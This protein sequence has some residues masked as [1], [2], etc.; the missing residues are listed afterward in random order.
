VGKDYPCFDSHSVLEAIA[1][2]VPKDSRCEV[3][4]DALTTR[5]VIDVSLCNPHEIPE[6]TCVGTLHK[7]FLRID[8]QDNG[9]SSVKTSFGVIRVRCVNSTLVENALAG[10]KHRHYGSIEDLERLVLQGTAS[11]EA[12]MNHYSA[13][14]E[15]ANIHRLLNPDGKVLEDPKEAFKLLI[16]N[17]WL[18]APTGG[19]K[20]VKE[21]LSQL[22]TAHEYEK[23]DSFAAYQRAATR[24]AHTNSWKSAF[25]QSDLEAQ[26][27]ALLYAKVYTPD[28]G[29]KEY[30]L[31]RSRWNNLSEKQNE[32]FS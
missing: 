19:R 9:L 28:A 18:K 12:I 1:K 4:Y 3:T 8:T 26:A 22:L 14:W 7:A 24:A 32:M 6:D 31:P 27:G 17:G 21:F 29:R 23:G 16:A 20:K 25:Y 11:F 15:S 13:K 30:A 10:A 2:V 5:A